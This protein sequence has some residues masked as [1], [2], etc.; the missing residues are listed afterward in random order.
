MGAAEVTK[1]KIT[2]I[3]TRQRRA[4]GAGTWRGWDSSP[5]GCACAHACGA[6]A[7]GASKV[8]EA[9]VVPWAGAGDTDGCAR[10]G[11]GSGRASGM[12]YRCSS[13]GS[14]GG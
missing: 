4:T 14:C 2:V 6:V 13:S 9:E 11:G 8:A 12:R 1:T 10:R 3:F 7:V 5:R